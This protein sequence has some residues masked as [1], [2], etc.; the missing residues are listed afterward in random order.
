MS[1]KQR[2]P[3]SVVILAA[4]EGKRMRSNLPKVLHH[5][6]GKSMLEHVLSTAYSLQPEQ[7]IVVHGYGG[8]KVRNAVDYPCK[9]VEQAERL[10]TADA[11]KQAL[12]LI[13]AEH[14]VLILYGDVPLI[15]TSTLERLLESS[16]DG[17][18][19]MITTNTPNPAG[20]GRIVRDKDQAIL[21]IVEERDAT[22]AQKRI[23]EV[24]SGIYA[25]IGE[26][27]QALMPKI[28]NDN[29]QKEFYLTDIV[30]LAV[31][32]GGRVVSVAPDHN[33]E[34]MGVNDKIQQVG[35][36]RFYQEQ[37]AI[38]LLKKG[39][40]I[41]DPKRLDCRGTLETGAGVK[42]DINVIFEGRNQLADNVSIGAH[43]V[44]KDCIIGEGATILPNSVLDG[45]TIGARC[46]VGP[47]AR[48]RPGAQ[49]GN[50]VRIGNF[51]EI[52]NTTISHFSKVNHLSYL[53]DAVL[54]KNVNVGAGT[55]TCNYD[56][57]YK[58][59]T[60]IANNVFIGSGTQLVAPVN[61]GEGATI[62]AGS[63][64]RKDVPT[65]QLTVTHRL[66]QRS[67][68]N[69]QRPSKDKSTTE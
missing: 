5:I 4:G 16:K 18:L 25:L 31:R 49:L 34:V 17:Q 28:T 48:L 2:N 26:Q 44:I 15:T 55:I 47:F 64:V 33:E 6:G 9:W 59:K 11:V 24:N 7:I 46:S 29:A 56:G 63:T 45:A 40:D 61:L 62:A 57:A 12:P 60:T 3:L 10:G 67:V 68:N 20:L 35:L 66:Q 42:V 38:N 1:A 52:K 43:C 37:L 19:G 41:V 13:G 32:D 14:Q 22:A 23:T 50:E 51:V 53:G 21:S 8:E 30:Q 39:I 36:E 65:G 69:W 27:L 54:G 58:H